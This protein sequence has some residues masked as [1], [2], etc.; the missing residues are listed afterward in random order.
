MTRITNST[1]ASETALNL[2][3][4]NFPLI[5]SICISR[6][7]SKV[8]AKPT[9]C[10]KCIMRTTDLFPYLSPTFHPC[11]LMKKK[12]N[13][14]GLISFL[15]QTLCFMYP[16]EAHPL[17]AEW[18]CL[19]MVE[20]DRGGHHP[21]A[22]TIFPGSRDLK[23]RNSSPQNPSHSFSEELKVNLRG[24]EWRQNIA[25]DSGYRKGLDR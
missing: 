8:N 24:K 10:L 1:I 23:R 6:R 12:K 17:K 21:W 5:K 20:R 22:N 7:K 16:P 13:V 14:F 9:E 15:S 3:H 11:S 18:K 19:Q 25:K 4:C 2:K